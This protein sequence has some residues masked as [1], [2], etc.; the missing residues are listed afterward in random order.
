MATCYPGTPASEILENFSAVAR[1]RNIY[2][3]W[4]VN[5]KVSMEVA[6]AGSFAGLRT[7]CTMKQCGVCVASDFLLHL[8]LTGTRGGMVIVPCDDPGAIGSINEGEARQ[9]GRMMELPVLEPS[10][11]QEAKEMTSGRLS[12][13]KKS[14]CRSSFAALQGFPMPAAS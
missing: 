4:S 14:T 5:E 12:F 8:S 3:E 1:D 10:D 7:L 11:P 2:V 6:A 9:F 13:P